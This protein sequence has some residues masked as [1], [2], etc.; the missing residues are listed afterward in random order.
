MCLNLWFYSNPQFSDDKLEERKK[1]KKKNSF[2][3]MVNT[4]L[5]LCL[6]PQQYGPFP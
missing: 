1:K 4:A 2:Y 5:Y 6:H 3:I